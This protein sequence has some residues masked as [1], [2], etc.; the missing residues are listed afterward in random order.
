MGFSNPLA[1]QAESFVPGVSSK[2]TFI[3]CRAKE[4]DPLSVRKQTL[5]FEYDISLYIGKWSSL[6]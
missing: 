4:T 3:M 6:L 2:N 1:S 5:T